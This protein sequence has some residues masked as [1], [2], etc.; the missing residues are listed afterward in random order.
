MSLIV[1]TRSESYVQHLKA[2]LEMD[3]T[4]RRKLTPVVAGEGSTIILHKSSFDTDV[5]SWLLDA[6]KRG[7]NVGV[8]TD[9]PDVGAML[10]YT[11]IGANAYFNSYMVDI[12][13]QQLIRLLED[14]LSW[15]S[16]TL[17]GEAFDLA[18]TAVRRVPENDPLD[19]LTIREKEIAMAVSEGK[20]NRQI[21]ED[22]NISERTVKTHLTNI[23]KKL[24]VKDRVALV[25]Y[26][27]RAADSGIAS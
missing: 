13:Y 17:L 25:I 27:N 6:R 18:R 5:S 21:A 16:P 14:G 7:A 9:Q 23:F 10:R 26:L 11:D 15:F 22:C 3:F 2:V 19:V 1:Y 8:A 20:Q 24:N 4:V 12:H